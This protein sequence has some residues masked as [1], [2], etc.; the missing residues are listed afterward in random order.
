[1]DENR[2]HP[3]LPEMFRLTFDEMIGDLKIRKGSIE[4]LLVGLPVAA[5]TGNVEMLRQIQTTYRLLSEEFDRLATNLSTY[6]TEMLFKTLECRGMALFRV[7]VLFRDFT[8]KF[9]TFFGH[10]AAQALGALCGD[11]FL[12]QELWRAALAV[13]EWEYVSISAPRL[14]DCQ[15]LRDAALD[16]CEIS[17]TDPRLARRFFDIILGGSAQSQSLM[18]ALFGDN[19]TANR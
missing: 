12:G 9:G 1:M 18:L 11:R 3:S 19:I 14:E 8:R 10:E 15:D 17:G 5:Q 6:I 2:L 16:Y 4:T 7:A 13:V